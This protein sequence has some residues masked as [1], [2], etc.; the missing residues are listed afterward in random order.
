[1]RSTSARYDAARKK[2]SDGSGNL[3]GQFEDFKQLCAQPKLA[4]PAQP[5]PFQWAP[6]V[7]HNG[8]LFDSENDGAQLELAAVTNGYHHDRAQELEIE[9]VPYS[10]S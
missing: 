9:E 7:E 2:L 8:Q 10:A 6:Q 5:V 4:R 1:L 3:A